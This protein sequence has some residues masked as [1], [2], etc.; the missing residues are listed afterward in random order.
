[1]KKRVP[2]R[3]RSERVAAESVPPN[4]EVLAEEEGGPLL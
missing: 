1:V 4:E 3:R 2:G